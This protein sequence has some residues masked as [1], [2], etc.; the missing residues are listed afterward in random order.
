M[1]FSTFWNSVSA[2]TSGTAKIKLTNTENTERHTTLPSLYTANDNY[3]EIKLYTV[4]A[5]FKLHV[6]AS[7]VHVKYKNWR[8]ITALM[9]SAKI[10]DV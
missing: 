9:R 2:R 8:H 4:R 7:V 1:L 5:D 3:S 10:T 6:S